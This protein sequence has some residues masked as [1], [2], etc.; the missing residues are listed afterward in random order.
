VYRHV[1]VVVDAL[2]P[3]DAVHRA[4]S[5]LTWPHAETQLVPVA[6]VPQDHLVTAARTHARPLG[7]HE[8]A[9]REPLP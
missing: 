7:F 1:T 2:S 5:E 8:A 4:V 9:T 6:V 3:G